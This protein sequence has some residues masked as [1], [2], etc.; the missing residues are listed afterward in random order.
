[1]QR[2]LCLF[3]C[4]SSRLQFTFIRTNGF[5]WW[6]RFSSLFFWLFF[7][8][9]I[10]FPLV[11]DEKPLA[12]DRLA[13]LLLFRRH[14]VPPF[15]GDYWNLARNASAFRDSRSVNLQ[16]LTWFYE[17]LNDTFNL[18]FH[19]FLLLERFKIRIINCKKGWMRIHLISMGWRARRP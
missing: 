10:V 18:F 2:V 4:S 12:S 19:L 9:I 15:A 8:F 11:N 3:P 7:F 5:L 14:F 13:S 16:Q 6:G 1:M 17:F